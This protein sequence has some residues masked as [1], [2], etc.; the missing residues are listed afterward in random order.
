MPLKSGRS[1]SVISQ[2]IREFSKGRTFARTKKKFGAATARKQA[3]AIALKK[4]GKSFANMV[5][6]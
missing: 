5:R 2:N 4:A 6:R 3:I 1:R